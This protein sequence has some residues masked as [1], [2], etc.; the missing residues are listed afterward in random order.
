MQ[1]NRGEYSKIG[2]IGEAKK[3]VRQPPKSQTIMSK[4]QSIEQYERDIVKAIQKH[5]VMCVS[6][7]F[8]VY[9][10]IASSQFYSLRLN[11]SPAVQEALAANRSR[12]CNAML[13]RWVQ[14]ENPTLQIAAY[15]LICTE[16]ERR[17]L[18]QSYVDHTTKGNAIEQP[19]TTEQAR[20]LLQNLNKTL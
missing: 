12:G 17:H 9:K 16:D 14:S 3:R 15:R 4:H 18:S 2:Q 7:I 13:T 20:A 5:G 10:G 1:R 19:I 6:H 11:E 8:G